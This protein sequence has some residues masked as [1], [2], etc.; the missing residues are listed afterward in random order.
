MEAQFSL[1]EHDFPDTRHDAPTRRVPEALPPEGPE[2]EEHRRTT[3]ITLDDRHTIPGGYEG[4]GGEAREVGGA[5]D[6][7]DAETLLFDR[8]TLPSAREV[9]LL[10]AEPERAPASFWVSL[11]QFF[12]RLT[13]RQTD[14]PSSLPPPP[15]SF[16]RKLLASALGPRPMLKAVQDLVWTLDESDLA[17]LMAHAARVASLRK[18]GPEVYAEAR[19]LDVLEALD[20]SCRDG[21]GVPLST[22]RARMPE[23][24]RDAFDAAILGLERK[25]WVVLAEARAPVDAS[26]IW[27]PGRGYLG[28]CAL[29]GATG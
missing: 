2:E 6:E 10:P 1:R 9:P 22:I 18:T 25:T 7:D 5:D 24:S 15:A 19:I 29:R 21:G 8:V 17:A 28:M 23:I 26:A 12:Q 16:T 3:L 4:E 14:R 11:R 20:A 27:A 13:R